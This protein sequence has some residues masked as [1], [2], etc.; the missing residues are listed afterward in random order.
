MSNIQI[1]LFSLGWLMFVGAM[2]SLAHKESIAQTLLLQLSAVLMSAG[3]YCVAQA[4]TL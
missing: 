2:W 3:I 4:A 1:A